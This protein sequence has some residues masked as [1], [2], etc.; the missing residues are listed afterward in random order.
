MPIFNINV[1]KFV[2]DVIQ[3]YAE[4]EAAAIV[5]A[6]KLPDI[7]QVLGAVANKAPTPTNPFAPI[8]PFA[9]N[10]HL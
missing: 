10:P 1:R 6:E 4:D 2:R 3:V 7:A 8:N 9:P 5:A